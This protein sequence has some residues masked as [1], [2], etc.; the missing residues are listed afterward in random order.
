MHDL[1][2]RITCCCLLLLTTAAA[3]SELPEI[4]TESRAFIR[5]W[6]LCGPFPNP[7][8]EGVLKY[9]HDETCLGYDRDY[10]E[11]IGGEEGVR[12]V[13]GQSFVASDGKR[14]TW[15]RVDAPSDR[16]DLPSFFESH[17]E[18]VAY[19]ACRLVAEADQ[20][21]LLGLG[22]NDGIKAWLNGEPI[23]DH[24]VPRSA[25][26]DF[27]W[28]RAR[29][30]KG[31]DNL[32]LLKI[33]QGW[34]AWGFYARLMDLEKKK[35]QLLAE[36]APNP[37][38]EV[39]L[40]DSKVSAV[41]GRVSRYRI[42]NNPPSCTFTFGG[43]ANE[44]IAT[45]HST[46]GRSVS[47][48][49]EGLPD[50][51]Y[52]VEGVADLPEGTTVRERS[53]FHHGPSAITARYYNR[54]GLP[55]KPEELMEIEL[56]DEFLSPV[57]GGVRLREPGVVEIL[58][59][60]IPR[61]KLRMLLQSQPLGRNWVVADNG[62][63]GFTVPRSGAMEIDLPS[64][65]ARS[66]HV[67]LERIVTDEETLPEWL[68]SNLEARLRGTANGD[69]QPT[70]SS[71]H[72]TIQIL[73]SL[74]SRLPSDGPTAVW[75]APNLEK[76][77][78]N[79]PVPSIESD[80]AHV[81]LARHEFE[82]FQV[83]IQ[84]VET[85]DDV[86]VTYIPGKEGR[87]V[88]F[89]PKNVSISLVDY[90]EIK[91]TTDD[92]GTLGWWPDPLPVLR[93]GVRAKAGENTAFWVTVYAPKEQAAGIYRGTLR[94]TSQ[95]DAF[96]D[97]PLEIEVYDFRL[98]DET[99]T[100][101]SFALYVNPEYHG[102]SGGEQQRAVHE[103]YMRFAAEHRISPRTPHTGSGI[104]IHYEGTPP[105]PVLDFSRFDRAMERYLDEYKFTS[106]DI[107]RLPSSIHGHPIYSEEYNRMFAETYG[108]VQEHL[109]N[110]G[111]LDRVYWYWIDEPL[112]Y[113]YPDV[114]KG[115]ELLKASSPD[116]RRLLTLNKEKAP[117]PYFHELCNLWIPL[118]SL[119]DEEAAQDRQALGE[120]VWWYVCCGPLAPYPNNFID[121]PA[122]NHRI[123]FWMMDARG[124]DGC[125]Y[126]SATWWT[127]NP[128]DVAM[129]Y[130][131]GDGRLIYP[132]RR[133]IPKEPVIEGPV[134]SIRFEALR[135]G[136]EDR[137][138]MVLL[139]ESAR[140]H[141]EKE[142]RAVR[143]LSQIRAELV[144]DLASFEMSPIPLT[145]TRHRLA[146]TIESNAQ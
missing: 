142:E 47:F 112:T 88:P 3:F 118:F 67:R 107:G 58:R 21:I 41:M 141:Q 90:V 13:E 23:W 94:F 83:A 8:A 46:L 113:S 53:F 19:A 133:K 108:E 128:W 26:P 89:D 17:Q 126:W 134:S 4:R 69:E 51:A 39:R 29:V 54:Q 45:V 40:A 33:G 61:F 20:T 36:G 111:W 145:V 102:I 103:L 123:R 95:D 38:V 125:L 135:D 74:K 15:K 143:I 138:Y 6:L 137:E 49:L 115:L 92:Y 109:R 50:G 110:K 76:I 24:H 78:K 97:V 119:Y 59:P 37:N 52:W 14:F 72:S 77:A 5:S 104:G 18:V 34:G 66:L 127:Q 146:K 82:A 55:P 120:T 2:R 98:P 25:D 44:P 75:C 65:V 130:G 1:T 11:P 124:V 121:H 81:S 30:R 85:L 9:S 12:P 87:V 80:C 73:T 117:M 131:N 99:H 57:P 28:I 63:Q 56:L 100:E 62:G 60:D 116:M 86:S 10:L 35:T 71:L 84:T 79:E 70:A 93:E 139:R 101:T 144:P 16:V 48:T 68:R 22:S 106:F 91:K 122:I 7:L 129:S 114:K 136:I 31:S 64:E 132:P 43:C 42:L 32:L 140:S 105:R 96:A 27:D